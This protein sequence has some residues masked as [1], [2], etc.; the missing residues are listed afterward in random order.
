MQ[1][2]IWWVYSQNIIE[3][4]LQT[5]PDFEIHKNKGS[6]M[7]YIHSRLAIVTSTPD[8]ATSTPDLFTLPTQPGYKVIITLLGRM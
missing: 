3:K 5:A 4:L 7:R 2:C 6:V 8:I 1:L